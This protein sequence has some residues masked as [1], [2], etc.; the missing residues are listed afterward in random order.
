MANSWYRTT[1]KIIF[2]RRETYYVY[3]IYRITLGFL[4]PK[5]VRVIASNFEKNIQAESRRRISRDDDYHGRIPRKRSYIGKVNT[6][7]RL[8]FARYNINRD[9]TF[10][11]KIIFSDGQHY[12]YT[13]K[14]KYE[15]VKSCKSKI[16]FRL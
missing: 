2:R 13:E 10:W 8:A 11:N 14:V 7:E 1:E 6:K 3:G 5:L 9:N 15:K 16:Y 12:T 4:L